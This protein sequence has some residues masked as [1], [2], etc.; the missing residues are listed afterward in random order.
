MV[1]SVSCTPESSHTGELYSCKNMIDSKNGDRD[2]HFHQNNG[3]PAH[4]K[5]FLKSPAYISR[6]KIIQRS[7]GYQQFRSFGL[8]R[9]DQF[10]INS[11]FR[12]INMILNF[13]NQISTRRIWLDK[14]I[15]WNKSLWRKNWHLK[16]TDR[17]RWW[18]NIFGQYRFVI[19]YLLYAFRKI[20]HIIRS[21][22]LDLLWSSSG[23][24]NQA[25]ARKWTE[26]LWYLRDN[27]IWRL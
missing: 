16:Y 9:F 5:L 1:I 14:Y 21:E 13:R 27:S 26:Q 10:L 15:K 25:Q 24:W 12:N 22:Y 7:T 6:V 3:G 11:L 20:I 23:R 17:Y 19:W 18:P 8:I 2:G 4:I